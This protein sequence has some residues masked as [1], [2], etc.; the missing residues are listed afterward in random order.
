MR[1]V[2]IYTKKPDFRYFR[3]RSTDDEDQSFESS[4]VIGEDP[5]LEDVAED[6]ESGDSETANEVEVSEKALKFKIST[7]GNLGTGRKSYPG[8]RKGS[9]ERVQH[10][11]SS[12]LAKMMQKGKL[13]SAAFSFDQNCMTGHK[14][15]SFDTPE[16]LD[17]YAITLKKKL[18]ENVNVDE[19]EK[20]GECV[21]SKDTLNLNK[22]NSE[23]CVKAPLGL[24]HEKRS[25][26]KCSD[27]NKSAAAAFT[28]LDKLRSVKSHEQED[29]DLTAQN[30]RKNSIQMCANST[31]SGNINSISCVKD[32]NKKVAGCADNSESKNPKSLFSRFRQF[33][34]RFGL[35]VDSKMKNPKNNNRFVSYY[36]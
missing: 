13:R 11:N 33:T 28:N 23:H 3:S 19:E 10:F 4:V 21:V 27:N 2:I 30:N 16:F 35:S 6:P 18:E 25:I 22:R 34:D 26:L 32:E 8:S 17:E 20:E 36:T 29:E 14:K 15:L 7:E 9:R 1:Y 5:S 31:A 12:D 24:E